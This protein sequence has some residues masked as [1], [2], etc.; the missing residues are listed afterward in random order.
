MVDVLVLV[1]VGNGVKVFVAVIVDVL[2][3]VTV[4]VLVFE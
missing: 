1:D 3:D 2:V 4:G